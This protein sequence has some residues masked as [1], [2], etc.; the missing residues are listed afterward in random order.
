METYE[1]KTDP[2]DHLDA[3]NDKMDMLLV[4][5]LARCKYFAIMLFR[6]AKNWIRKIEPEIINSWVQLFGMFM[7]QF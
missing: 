7:G 1:G 4:T 6:T 5:P 3:F 2:Q